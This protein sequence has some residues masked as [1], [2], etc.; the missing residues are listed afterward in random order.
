M[1][2]QVDHIIQ[3]IVQWVVEQE[4]ISAAALVGS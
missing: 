3:L 2:Q 1:S 4:A